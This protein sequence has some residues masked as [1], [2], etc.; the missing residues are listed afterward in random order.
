QIT[1]LYLPAG[2]LG[3]PY[4]AQFQTQPLPTWQGSFTWSLAPNSAG[5][6]PGLDL[7]SDG[8]GLISGTP[9]QTGTFDFVIRV[10]DTNSGRT[11][12]RSFFITVTQCRPGRTCPLHESSL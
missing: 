6:P 7:A 8:S 5:L 10:T 3:T 12:D 9:T 4:Q 11:V 2:F 1:P